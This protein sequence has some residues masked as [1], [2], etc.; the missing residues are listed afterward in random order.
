MGKI[1]DYLKDW[2]WFERIWLLTFTIVNIYLFFAWQDTIVGLTASI[3][4]MICVVLTAKAKISS[5]YFG[6]VN[7]LTYSY[8]AYQ[9]SYYGDVMLNMLYFLPMTFVGIYF[10]KKN[11]KLGKTGEVKVRSL[12]WRKRFLWFS[13]SI[14]ALVLYGGILTLIKGT[15]PFVDSATTVFSVIAT[16]MLNKRLTEQWFY[17]ILVDI[18][19]IVMWVYIF[20]TQGSDISILVMWSAFLVNAVY[21]LYNWKKMEKKQN[22]K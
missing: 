15:L 17:W 7:I 1:K 20:F 10:W 14:V 2:N 11:Q 21:G 4:G 22:G 13:L 9:S 3:T 12:D 19:S 16:I 18:L 5:F 8:V 6:F